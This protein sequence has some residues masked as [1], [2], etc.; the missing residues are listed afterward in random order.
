[1]FACLYI[2]NINLIM[3]RKIISTLLLLIIGITLFSG[4]SSTTSNHTQIENPQENSSQDNVAEDNSSLEK[5]SNIIDE[6]K[7]SQNFPSELKLENGSLYCEFGDI[8]DQNPSVGHYY[9]KQKIK[10]VSSPENLV[11]TSYTE[12]GDGVNNYYFESI[13]T[14]GIPASCSCN[15]EVSYNSNPHTIP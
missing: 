7:S 1:M 12:A 2:A 14:H 8:N 15:F 3:V 10:I 9:S 11:F 13:C 4:C 6:S 5:E